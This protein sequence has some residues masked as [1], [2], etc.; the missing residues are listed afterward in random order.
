MTALDWQRQAACRDAD[1]ELFT[2]EDANGS[3]PLPTRIQKAAIAWCFRCPVQVECL[4]YALAHESR[5]MRHGVWGGTTP[6]QRQR[7]G[8]KGRGAA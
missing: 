4:E 5:D 7:I 2:G 8:K 3:G 1:P 6:L